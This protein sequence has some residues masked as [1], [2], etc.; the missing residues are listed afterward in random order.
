MISQSDLLEGQAKERAMEE[1][2]QLNEQN[3]SRQIRDAKPMP[4]V[5]GPVGPGMNGVARKHLGDDSVL[6]ARTQHLRLKRETM[7]QFHA[8]TGIGANQ[9]LTF[10]LKELERLYKVT[11]Q[12]EKVEAPRA[13]AIPDKFKVTI[14]SHAFDSHIDAHLATKLPP[15]MVDTWQ[16]GI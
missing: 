6:L 14:E 4:V 3:L 12:Q 2:S 13:V 16:D 11:Q 5:A 7:G 15:N 1:M 9:I 8:R 10:S